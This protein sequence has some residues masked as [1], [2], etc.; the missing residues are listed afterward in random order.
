MACADFPL[1]WESTGDQWWCAAPIDWAAANGHY[2]LLR[3]LLH[4]DGNLIIKL[5]SLRRL[6]RLE[7]LWDDDPRFSSAAAA[8]SSIAHKLLL[9]C[10]SP[11]G[12]NSLLAAGY[13]GWLLYTAAAAGDLV[14]SG[15]L[16]RRD[17]FLVFGEGEYG[18]TDLLYAAAR[19]RSSEVFFLL[20]DRAA[21]AGRSAVFAAEIAH[22]AVLAAA[23]GG[24]LELTVELL[25]RYGGDVLSFRDAAGST[26][27][28]A[29]AA[30]G[31]V[32]VVEGLLR[33]Y[34]I[35]DERDGQGNAAVHVAAYR[36][37]GAAVEALILAAPP[38]AYATNGA[39]ENVLHVAVAGFRA[40]G[41]RRLDRQM[42]VVRFLLH[43]RLVDVGSLVN[44][45]DRQGRTALH[46]AAARNIHANVVALLMAVPSVEV[47][48][49]D[50]NGMTALDLLRRRP[51]TGSS[52]VV[53]RRL[54]AAGGIAGLKDESTRSALVAQLR[55]NPP[56]ASPGTRFRIAD[57]EI[58]LF[59][60]GA[61]RSSG[62]GRGNDGDDSSEEEEERRRDGI[63]LGR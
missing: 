52:E 9:D 30:R 54:V 44:A 11:S 31:H 37:Q 1:R 16:L 53:L 35:A 59:A 55:A 57:S 39:G 27:L 12:G 6:R 26:V 7:S 36:G 14:F 41:F 51:R 22:R 63:Q 34:D 28:H 13:G 40:S 18:V 46:V 38:C 19:S 17:P 29:A 25:R 23:R 4:I 58:L 15:E 5:T 21:A 32:Q 56:A 8:R 43:G 24:S 45:R 33:M 50:V 10:E 47:N 62:D 61:R 20:L 49:R 2:D 42:A 48:A 3:E 60:G